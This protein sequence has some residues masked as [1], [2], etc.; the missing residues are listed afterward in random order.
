MVIH[1]MW[2]ILAVLI[3]LPQSPKTV[4]A[5][6]ILAPHNWANGINCL[7]CHFMNPDMS[8]QPIPRGID[9]E[10]LCKTCHN[11][12]GDAASLGAVAGH[13]LSSGESIME[14]SACHNAH[15]PLAVFDLHSG[16]KADNLNLISNKVKSVNGNL[17]TAVFQTKPAHFAFLEDNPP[18]NG[19]CQTCHTQTKYHRND[20]TGLS[21]EAGTKCTSCHKHANGFMALEDSV[22]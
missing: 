3:V 5:Q 4:R 8:L 7:N 10:S 18:F 1:L 21:H 13:L 16:V 15:G 2:L 17:I 6:D 19:I 14:C 20:G 9:Q 12:S 22:P 11:P